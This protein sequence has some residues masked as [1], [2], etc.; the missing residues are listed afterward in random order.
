[1]GDGLRQMVVGF[2]LMTFGIGCVAQ[3]DELRLEEG[4]SEELARH[5]RATLADLSYAYELSVP[6]DAGALTGTLI[7]QFTLRDDS[8]SPVVIDFKDPG[9]RVRTVYVNGETAEWTAAFDHLA[10]DGSVFATDAH[11]EV[12]IEFEAG[13]EAL[14]RNPDFLYTLFV[15]DRAHF[16]LPVHIPRNEADPDLSPRF[17]RGR[18]SDRGG[19]TGGTHLQ[20]VPSRDRYREGGP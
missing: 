7:T 8:N 20:D 11:N 15:P 16:S 6:R 5:R 13:D 1:M 17:C 19:G 3:P 9:E 12:S 10:I 4:V 18:L 14:N 2:G